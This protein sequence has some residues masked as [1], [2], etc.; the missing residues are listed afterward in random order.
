MSNHQIL[1]NTDH[2]TLR[3]HAEASVDLGDDVMA[4][5]AVPSEFRQIQGEFPIVFRRDIE[6]GSFAAM[7]L[8][9]FENGE[10]LFLENG[11]WTARYRPL[12]LAIQPFLV[13]RPA[14]ESGDAQ[15]HLDMDHK[16]ISKDGEG[17]RVFDDDGRPTPYLESIA[18]RLGLLHEGYQNSGEFIAALAR[19]ELL[20][21]FTLEVPL[22][23]GSKHS[24]VGFHTIDEEKLRAL[25]G[26][27]LA[28]LQAD[29]HLLPIFMTVA[30]LAQF[31]NLVERKN[32]R[33]MRA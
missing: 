26:D 20:E 13:G 24:L 25:D 31:S 15:V 28:E 14:D 32:D 17:T 1:N 4:C 3:I 23:D 11:K 5:L 10:N 2:L 21:P 27:A 33:V 18:G 12:A 16:R 9:G 29:G 8:F 19:H 7:A 6:N 30:S 22:R